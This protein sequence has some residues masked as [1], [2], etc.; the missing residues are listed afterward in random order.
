M[1]PAIALLSVVLLLLNGPRALAQTESVV[2]LEAPLSGVTV[3]PEG[4]LCEHQVRLQLPAG[5]SRVTMV[6]EDE[7]PTNDE[8]GAIDRYRGL[9]R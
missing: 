4:A 2:E 5:R 9:L 6:L 7:L 1:K 3:F 8:R